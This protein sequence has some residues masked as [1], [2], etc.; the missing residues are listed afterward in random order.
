MAARAKLNDPET[1]Q[2][3]KVM[4]ETFAGLAKQMLANNTK[5]ME[6]VAVDL[7]TGTKYKVRISSNQTI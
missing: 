6:C 2:K 4:A 5:N 1:Q 3:E 7:A